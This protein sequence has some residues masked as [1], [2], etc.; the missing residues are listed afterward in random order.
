MSAEIKSDLKSIADGLR[1]VRELDRD[2]AVFGAE[3]HRYAF[4]VVEP[5]QVEGLEEELG[6]LLPDEYRAFL[7]GLG[8]GAGPYYGLWS[9]E[10]V[11]S[12]VRGWQSQFEDEGLVC[13]SPAAAFV[14]GTGRFPCDGVL[15]IGDQGCT[16]WSALVITGPARGR[17]VDVACAEGVDGYLGDAHRP[18]GTLHRWWLPPL[19]L[20]PGFL[21]WYRSWLEQC[22]ADL[23]NAHKRV[24]AKPQTNPGA[25]KGIWRL[26]GGR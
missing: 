9:P 21:D 18:P 23:E 2:R 11:V 22:K 19:K 1:L 4:K 17:I 25:K 13:P 24:N 10:K 15:A 12:D 5:G 7:L 26:F 3:A 8:C 20:N 6:V 14:P 16:F